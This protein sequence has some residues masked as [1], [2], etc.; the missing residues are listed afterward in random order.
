MIKL[1]F[2]IVAVFLTTS[3]I[4]SQENKN[5]RAI[6]FYNTENLFD[7]LNDSITNDDDFT[8]EG[9]YHWTKTKYYRKINNIS[10]VLLDA[11]GWNT[12]FLIGLCE[13]ENDM[14]LEDL[15]Y[16]GG[17]SK[18]HYKI[19]HYD[20]HDA[21]G[22]DVA[23]LYKST[24]FS[25][26][27]SEPVR[28]TNSDK[29]FKTRDILYVKGVVDKLDTVHLFINH[30][31]SRRGGEVE[32]EPKRLLAAT[33]LRE[34]IDS[35][36]SVNP[37]ALILAMGDFNDSPNDIA[38]TSILLKPLAA[39][40]SLIPLAK[41]LHELGIGSHKFAGEWNMID[42]MFISNTFALKTNPTGTTSNGFNIVTLPYL[43]EDDEVNFGKK[44]VRTYLGPRYIGGYSDHFPI[45]FRYEN[46]K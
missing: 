5:E 24:I 32:S 19:I 46:T 9:S 2:V 28:V 42:Q 33:I 23:L 16:M 29:T 8:P 14:V 27:T 4:F 13:I 21:R 31:P 17:L 38:I 37:N 34:K 18:L 20:S 15:L 44:L 40:N 10:K 1:G 36:C 39:N 26:L 12:P 11:N 3:A 22:I 25:P 35:I 43:T 7:T 6:L 30:F 45:I 41:P